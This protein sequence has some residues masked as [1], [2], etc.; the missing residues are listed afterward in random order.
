MDQILAQLQTM[1]VAI[2][3]IPKDIA[4]ATAA[5]EARA[6]QHTNKEVGKLREALNAEVLGRDKQIKRLF[7][8]LDLHHRALERCMRTVNG[9]KVLLANWGGE[10]TE[11]VRKE[12]IKDACAKL[13]IKAKHEKSA[14]VKK[15][16]VRKECGR[17]AEEGAEGIEYA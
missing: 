14:H 16:G 12:K 9:N 8:T 17:N 7:D 13:N 15:Q 2:K 3:K 1:T 4:E 5:A 11:S 6:N 10:D